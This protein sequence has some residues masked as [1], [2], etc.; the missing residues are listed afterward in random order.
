MAG[1]DGKRCLGCL[2]CEDLVVRDKGVSGG[3]RH[4]EAFLDEGQ[5]GMRKGEK[6]NEKACGKKS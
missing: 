1:N 4:D 6:G 2:E 3:S 5:V